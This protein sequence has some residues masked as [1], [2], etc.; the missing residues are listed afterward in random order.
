MALLEPAPGQQTQGTAKPETSTRE[1]SRT[2]SIGLSD[3]LVFKPSGT[4]LAAQ[5]MRTSPRTAP[6]MRRPRLFNPY[7]WTQ[8]SLTNR[9]FNKTQHTCLAGKTFNTV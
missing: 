1:D 6:A 4:G 2:G 8:A 7:P 9:K 3:S 5:L